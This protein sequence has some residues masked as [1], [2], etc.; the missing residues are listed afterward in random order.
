MTQKHISVAEIAPMRV[1]IV[2]MDTHL[3]SA[4][5]RARAVLARDIPGLSLKVHAASEY[6]ADPAALERCLADIAVGD[7]IISYPY[8]PHSP[9]AAI[10]VMRWCARCLPVKS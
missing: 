4:T 9:P 1:V 5:A 8:C 7:I 2:T 6:A 3:A 10:N